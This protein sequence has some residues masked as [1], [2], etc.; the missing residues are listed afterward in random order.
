[1]LTLA[2]E[3]VAELKSRG[4]AQAGLYNPEGVGGTHVMYVLHHADKPQLY[5]GLPANPGISPTVTFG[6]GS[7]NRWRRWV[8]PLRSPP[9]FFTMLALA[10]IASL[11]STTTTTII[12]RS[13]NNE[14]ARSSD[15]LPRTRTHQSL[16]C[17]DLL[18]HGRVKRI[19]VFLSVVQLADADIW[20]TTAGAYS[21]SFCR[22]G[23]VRCFY[24]D[25]FALLETQPD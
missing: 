8:L 6:R 16:D 5:H 22:R 10:R 9:L 21:A 20:H 23:D 1:M 13:A 7:G 12:L 19:R 3:R 11:K 4:F 18:C 2:E 14:K 25:V 17:R 15:A 24:A